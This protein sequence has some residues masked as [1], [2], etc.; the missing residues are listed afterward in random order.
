MAES[1]SMLRSSDP[2]EGNSEMFKMLLVFGGCDTNF[3]YL[4]DLW[5]FNL[6]KLRITPAIC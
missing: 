4:N 1:I 6:G 3:E 2:F 5:V